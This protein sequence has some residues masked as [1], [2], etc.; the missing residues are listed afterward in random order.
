MRRD[1]SLGRCLAT[2]VMV[3]VGP[4]MVSADPAAHASD[5]LFVGWSAAM[6]SLAFHYEAT[7]SDACVA[8]RVSCVK[9]TVREMQDRFAVLSRRCDHDAVFALAY[10]RTTQTYLEST[11]AEGYFREP[12]LVNHED[13]AFARMYLQAYDNWEA[14]R[15]SLVPR[16]WRVAL[17]AADGRSVSGTGN[18]LLGMNAHIN[19]DLPFVLAATGLVAPDGV[20]RKSDHDQINLM[21]N[22]VV[23]PLVA[24][25]AQRFDPA[26]ASMSTPYGVGY[27]GLMQMLVVWRENA[28]RQAERLVA[29]PSPA[30]RRRVA[31]Q[32]EA[33]AVTQARAMVAATAFTPPLTTTAARDRYCALHGNPGPDRERGS[34]RWR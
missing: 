11:L 25:E 30:A 33:A 9:R 18:L 32:I 10:L 14:G 17:V 4:T 1:R 6:P 7:S 13:V 28:W 15:L 29:A 21:L 24:E 20:S 12:S 2:T 23:E 5:P 26:I 19:R 34:K 27:T 31:Q 8:G 3:L 22:H 16:A